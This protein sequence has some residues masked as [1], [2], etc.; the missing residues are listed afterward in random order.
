MLLSNESAMLLSA[1][2]LPICGVLYAIQFNIAAQRVKHGY[3]TGCGYDIR[4]SESRCPEC[5]RPIP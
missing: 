3:C 1:L 4:A 5:G 2:T